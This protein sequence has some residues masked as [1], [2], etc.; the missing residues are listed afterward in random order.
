MYVGYVNGYDV[1]CNVSEGLY[2]QVSTTHVRELA[3]ALRNSRR[4]E[5]LPGLPA[6]SPIVT[7]YYYAKF[8]GTV[9][10]QLQ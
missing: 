7:Y 4:L 3:E 8:G 2:A 10:C 1:M 5:C 9:G 6:R